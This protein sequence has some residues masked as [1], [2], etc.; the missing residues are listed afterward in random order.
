MTPIL[1]RCCTDAAQVREAL[2]NGASR[3][4][5][6]R[7]LETGGLTPDADQIREAVATGLQVNVHVRPR[8]GDFV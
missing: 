4:E 5:L 2:E 6:C 1:E 7:C 8:G 3:A